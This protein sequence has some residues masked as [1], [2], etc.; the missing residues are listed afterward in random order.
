MIKVYEDLKV[1]V[2]T[3][4]EFNCFKYSIVAHAYLIN[5]TK[6]VRHHFNRELHKTLKFVFY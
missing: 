5:Y 3:Y 2:F 1:S 6:P 4:M